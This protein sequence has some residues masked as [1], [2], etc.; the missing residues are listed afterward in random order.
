MGKKDS[1]WFKH[2]STAGRDLRIMQI[3]AIY[4][5]EGIGIF[6]SVVEVL[7]E[8]ANFSWK[9]DESSLGILSKIID[10]DKTTLKNFIADC[11]RIGLLNFSEDGWVFS[12]R[13]N[14]D[15]GVWTTKRDNGSGGGKA[16]KAAFDLKKEDNS[17]K[18]PNV[19][20]KLQ[21]N[22][23]ES[24]GIREEKRRED[25]EDSIYIGFV[26]FVNNTLNRKFTTKDSKAKRQLIARLKDG[27]TNEQIKIAI[28]NASK[29]SWHI[30]NKYKYLSP[31]FF[32]RSDKIDKFLNMESVDVLPTLIDLKNPNE[33]VN[34]S[35][36]FNE[37]EVNWDEYP[38]HP[39]NPQ[40]LSSNGK[41]N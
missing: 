32:T 14:K 27:Y 40:N 1:Y 2:D 20:A 34:P 30:E 23:S 35:D 26:S 37:P 6:W 31:E 12:N 10:C 41:S 25:K 4:G 38:N 29:D 36:Y 19:V 17:E 33:Y 8:Q 24:S 3:K 7:R 39:L 5:L 15:M 28:V 21:R 16:K 11:K 13:L 18:I 9:S 22:S